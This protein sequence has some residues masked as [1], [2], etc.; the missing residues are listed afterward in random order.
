MEQRTQSPTHS[1]YLA[2][3]ARLA[4]AASLAGSPF[5]LTL[6]AHAQASVPDAAWQQCAALSADPQARL[7]CFDQWAARHTPAAPAGAPPLA[8]LP[9][10]TPPETHAATGAPASPSSALP[11]L[12]PHDCRSNKF[13]ELSRFWE[14]EPGSDCGTFGIRGFK[15]I[16]LSW[17]G[18]D[19]VN[20]Q[21]SSPSPNHTATSPIAYSNNEAR[22]Q[23]S[24]RTKIAQGL[25]TQATPSARDSLWFGYTQQ[26]NWQLFSG[27]ISRP[28]RTTD[29]AP[30]FTYIH[31][32]S[33]ELPGGWRLRYT[34]L[35]LIHQSNGQSEPLSRSWNRTILSAGLEKDKD[36]V[37]TG[38][39]WN[40]LSE[41]AEDDDN[42]DI[43][44][45]VGRAQVAGYWNVNQNN[46]LGVTVRHTLRANT[47]GSVRLEWLRD[48]SGTGVAGGR[49]GL[50]FHAQ[51][52]SGYGDSLVDYNRQRT[53][54][55]LGLSLVDW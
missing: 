46:T 1:F 14:L 18:A 36:F 8:R 2:Q 47:R 28:F 12:A 21:P 3:S 39:L 55:T 50:R 5:W 27:D 35:S 9:V 49:S 32:T 33:A 19:S 51:L 4:I 40:R 22:I 37:L 43:S 26:S 45:Y 54:L 53:V 34:G 15:P 41:N 16:T 31:P 23:L 6:P 52:F 10:H 25:L 11:A 42:P 29:H 24:V 20:T 48:L 30:E 13:S 44:D 38:E 17:V 7:D